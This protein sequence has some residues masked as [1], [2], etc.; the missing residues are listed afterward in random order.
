M[1]IVW[2]DKQ[3]LFIWN[4]L[5]NIVYTIET[6]EKRGQNIFYIIMGMNSTQ[7]KLICFGAELHMLIRNTYP[8]GK[9][10]VRIM[11]LHQTI[12]LALPGYLSF[13]HLS[14]KSCSGDVFMY[15]WQPYT[16]A[17]H[18]SKR[19]DKSVNNSVTNACN[20]ELIN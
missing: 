8:E 12:C 20:S 17:P 7:Q 1:K 16:T 4:Y 19:F 5:L 14:S 15:H 10:Y 9:T 2:V 11:T 3:S 13:N 6:K 18:Y